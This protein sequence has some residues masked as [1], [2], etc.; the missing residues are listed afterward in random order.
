MKEKNQIFRWSNRV[1]KTY[2]LRGIPSKCVYHISAWLLRIFHTCSSHVSLHCII[3]FWWMQRCRG[4]LYF[5]FWNRPIFTGTE[6]SRTFETLRTSSANKCAPCIEKLIKSLILILLFTLKPRGI[7]LG[8]R[9]AVDRSH[10][11]THTLQNRV[12]MRQHII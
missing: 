11:H 1:H 7:S 4:F 2:C 9:T 8:D 3:C 10:T 6:A 5:L 12:W